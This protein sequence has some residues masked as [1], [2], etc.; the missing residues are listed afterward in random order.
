MTTL[1]PRPRNEPGRDNDLATLIREIDTDASGQEM[2]TLIEQ[3]FPLCRSITG[4]GLRQTLKII[5]E[6]IPLRIH[7][8]PTGTKVFDWEIPREW[9]ISDAYVMNDD[10]E[11]V[12]NFKKSNLHVV[13]YSTPISARMSL[14]ELRPHLHTLPDQPDWIP[15]RT[16]YYE[17]D[18]GFCLAFKDYQSLKDGQ[19]D[20]QI[21][22]TLEPGSLS[23]GELILEG[24]TDEKIL[25]FAHVCHPSLC[26]DNLSGVALL[27][28]LA[29]LLE[30]M[31]L[32]YTYHFVFAPATIGSITWLSR[33]EAE[34][35]KI[36][37]G[38]VASVLGDAGHMHY[39]RTR[40][41]S[42][43]IDRAVIH[44]LEQSGDPFEIM[45][46]S[47][48]GYD[49]RQFCSPGIGLAVG[50]LTRSPN[51]AYPE[52]H[53]S[54]DNMTLVRPEFLAK[55]LRTYLNVLCCL[56][57]NLGYLNL[58]PKGEPQLGR[59]GLYRKMGG[60]QDIAETQLAMLWMLNLSDGTNSVLDIAERSEMHYLQLHTAATVLCE[61]GLLKL[62]QT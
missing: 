53:T 37:H 60:F 40:S 44:V 10:G 9:N 5:S 28:A 1:R 15:Y 26:N 6:H 59:R 45:D 14:D 7:E 50:R 11:R 58:Q 48:W 22:A 43:I 3:L 55:S 21:D 17:E 16:T 32:R 18:W 12:I 38:L 47:P 8:V 51:G 25:L 2:F 4:D 56:E 23:Y 39:K 41:E 54:A 36:R 19:Y 30:S 20:V 46:F 31:S 13:N 52:Y 62:N 61:H 29:T 57:T 35:P 34:L 27:T 33:N 49:E 24:E 42:E